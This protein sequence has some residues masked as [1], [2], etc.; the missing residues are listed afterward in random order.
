VW[1]GPVMEP[2][3]ESTYWRG[4]FPNKAGIAHEFAEKNAATYFE[5][6]TTARLLMPTF[7]VLGGLIVFAWSRRVFGVEGGL[8][9]LVLWAFCPNVLAHARLVTTDVGATA[10]GVGATFLFWRYLQSPTWL[11]ASAAGIALGLAELSKFSL[12]LLYGLWPFLW[13][14]HELCRRELEGLSSRVTRAAAQGVWMV[15]LSVLLIDLAYC[16]EGVGDRLGRFDFVSKMLTRPVE[17]PR[18]Y[19]SSNNQLRDIARQHRVNRFRGTLLAGV[20]SPLPRHYLLGFDAQKIEAEAIP[21]RWK[22][23]QAAEYETIGYPVYLDG[24][25]RETGWWYYYFLALAYKVP[26]GTIAL[27][28]LSVAVCLCSRRARLPCGDEVCL[29]A[30]PIVVLAVMSFGTDIDL[31]LRYVLPIFPYIFISA[32][33]VVLWSAGMASKGKRLV[34]RCVVGS[35]LCAT[36]LATLTIHPHYLAY[37]NW[38]SGGAENG[39]E[40]LIDSNLD[41]GQDLVN[42]KRWIKEDPRREPIGIAYFGQI[43]P[44]VFA[45]RQEGLNWFLPPSLPGTMQQPVLGRH[46]AGPP[47]PGLY[48][49]SASLVRGLPWRVYD[50]SRWAPYEAK[51]D[52]FG[53]FRELTPISKIGIGYSIFIYRVTSADTARLAR[54]WDGVE[55]GPS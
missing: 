54:Y 7:S 43:N 10:L 17:P 44:N 30:V 37:F 29:W 40:H 36:V 1:A 18:A 15:V 31:G 53:Y 27:V 16:F 26:E 55:R 13:L 11:R 21:K 9:S 48:A 4:E 6:F 23:P 28:L 41:W 22:D 47:E 39:S 8:T 42:L 25:L 20:P 50:S 33:R 34:A 14:A 5:L 52:A 12:I 32:G 46:R 3:Y 45:L 35:C 38:A 24:Q 51:R 19:V 2:I 49:V